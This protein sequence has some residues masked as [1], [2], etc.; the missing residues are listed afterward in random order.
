MVTVWRGVAVLLWMIRL[1]EPI[2]VWVMVGTASTFTADTKDR[3]TQ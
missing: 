2:E 1:A 3:Y